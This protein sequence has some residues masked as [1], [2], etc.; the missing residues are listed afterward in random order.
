MLGTVDVH[1]ASFRHRLSWL[2]SAWLLFQVAGI[3]AP[4][5]LAA[6]GYAL[7][8]DVCT[9]PGTE[10]GAT[11]PMHHGTSAGRRADDADCV[12]QNAS[13]QTDVA[14]LS[15]SIGS[16]EPPAA[17]DFL[18]VPA[19]VVCESSTRPDPASRVRVPDSPPPRA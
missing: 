10:H 8:E 11:C 12:L 15:L 7:G 1:V 18:I 3:C 4:V 9:C 14:L 6:A 19:S 2:L 5:A 16:G 13:P 17:L